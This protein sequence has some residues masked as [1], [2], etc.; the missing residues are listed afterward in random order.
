MPKL[1]PQRRICV[2]LNLKRSSFVAAVRNVP[3]VLHKA[4]GA[5]GEG[6]GRTR[7]RGEHGGLP[8]RPRPAMG[9]TA[10]GVGRHR[11]RARLRHQ[12]DVSGDGGLGGQRREDLAEQTG[13]VPAQEA[14]ESVSCDPNRKG[15]TIASRCGTKDRTAPPASARGIR[16][17]LLRGPQPLPFQAL[18][19]DRQRRPATLHGRSTDPG[20][21]AIS[22]P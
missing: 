13:A 2:Q 18:R 17:P 19:I 4:L 10:P 12:C 1:L 3:D 14:V 20:R 22:I 16:T 7:L 8:R 5:A 15:I 9:M 6:G 21:R 11:R